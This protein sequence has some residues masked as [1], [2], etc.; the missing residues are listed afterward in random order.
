M[1][2]HLFPSRTQK[3]STCTPTIL[4]GRLPGKIG[5]A[6][7]EA[8]TEG[9]GLFLCLQVCTGHLRT[10]GQYVGLPRKVDNANTEA[11]ISYGGGFFMFSCTSN[12]TALLFFIHSIAPFKYQGPPKHS[13]G[14]WSIH[15]LNSIA[16]G[17]S[18]RVARLWAFLRIYSSYSRCISIFIRL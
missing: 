15:V 16:N 2:V 13:G 8:S 6:N 14:P 10:A 18:T 4:G 5:N 17:Q 11:S 9:S 3:L 7:T 1:W 12:C